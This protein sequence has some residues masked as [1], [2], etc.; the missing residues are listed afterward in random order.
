MKSKRLGRGL[1]A[2]IP[3]T[4]LDDSTQ[5]DG[6]LRGIETAKINANPY[7]PR[8]QF[9]RTGLEELKQSI[10]ENGVIQPITVRKSGAGYELVAGERR[11]RA[12]KELGYERI[13]AYVIEIKSED[14]MLEMALVEN[15]QREDLNPIELAKAYQQLQ[16]EYGLT[17][18]DVAQKVGKDRTT[19]ANFIRLLK[20]PEEIQASLEKRDISMG[21]A[22]AIMGLSHSENQ[23]QIWRKTIKHS[24]SV[25]QL[26]EVVRKLQESPKKTKEIPKQSPGVNDVEERLRTILGTRVKMKPS[27]RGGGKL[28]ISYYS[29]DDLN[30]ILELIFTIT[31]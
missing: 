18:E 23:I 24:W 3:Q 27:T 11:F 31:E 25:R 6:S 26:E 1:E 9:D 19:V 28:E 30:R 10:Q 7:Q 20:L 22:R 4:D 8:N 15:V 21:H 5:Q 16:R 14:Q 2:L 17:Q 13:P 12:V 29:D